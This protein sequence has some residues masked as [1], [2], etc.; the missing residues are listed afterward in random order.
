MGQLFSICKQRFT[1]STCRIKPLLMFATMTPA[2]LT[3]MAFE[4]FRINFC[5]RVIDV[6]INYTL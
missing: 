2:L 3:K 1:I 5:R 4:M 6:E